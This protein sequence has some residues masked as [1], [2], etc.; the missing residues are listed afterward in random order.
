MP[1]PRCA[2]RY[3][4]DRINLCDRLQEF[5]ALLRPREVGGGSWASLK[6]R[7]VM[8]RGQQRAA[9]QGSEIREDSSQP[10]Q[11]TAS[12]QMLGLAQKPRSVV[13]QAPKRPPRSGREESCRISS[14]PGSPLRASSVFYKQ[15]LSQILRKAANSPCASQMGKRSPRE[16]PGLAPSHHR[17]VA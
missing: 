10:Q 14:F 7:G 13:S 1:E 8:G 2:G 17:H 3:F 11:S 5:L 15:Q 4:S 9:A 12:L 6:G 16:E